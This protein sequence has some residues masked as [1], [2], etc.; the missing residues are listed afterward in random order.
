MK[1]KFEKNEF[2]SENPPGTEWVLIRSG[3]APSEI[4]KGNEMPTQWLN[5]GGNIFVKNENTN[6]W[7]GYLQKEKI[8]VKPPKGWQNSAEFVWKR[9]SASTFT[10]IRESLTSLFSRKKQIDLI[11]NNGEVDWKKLFVG[12]PTRAEV[13]PNGTNNMSESD[14]YSY[15]WENYGIFLGGIINPSEFPELIDE[16]LRPLCSA[17][18]KTRWAR[19]VNSCSGHPSTGKD[20]L[21]GRGYGKPFLSL[22]LDVN[23]P[24]ANKLIDETSELGKEWE[25]KY[26]NLKIDLKKEN[27]VITKGKPRI[28]KFT[29]F[30]NIE[31]PTDTDKK[32][33][34]DSEECRQISASFFKELTKRIG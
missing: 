10:K 12:T 34:F 22:M 30:L 17:I 7:I 33:Y 26:S 9:E 28:V 15:F 13:F 27:T 1:E 18:N 21:K 6:E 20:H 5:K 19:S 14:I 2:T 32:T 24:K 16:G 4:H 23:D 29:L 8:F 31:P 3:K 11:K 25:K